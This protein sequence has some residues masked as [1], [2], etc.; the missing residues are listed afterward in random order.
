[1]LHPG[2]ISG[3]GWFPI[4]PQGNFNPQVY[5]DIVAGREILLPNDGMATIHPV[6]ADDIAGLAMAVL[7]HPGKSCGEAFNATAKYAVTLRGY[8][9]SLYARFGKE[10]RLRFL[11]FAEFAGEVSAE[12][13]E[14]TLEH[15]SRS[16]NCSMEKAEKLLGFV[17]SHSVVDTVESAV[18]YQIARGEL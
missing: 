9:E 7:A 18:R 15:I 17:P 12:D 1:M 10:P 11:P 6:H 14:Q 8:A 4:N 2:H 16:P 13:A 5:A 3:D